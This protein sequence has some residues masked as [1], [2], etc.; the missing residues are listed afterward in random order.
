MCFVCIQ[1]KSQGKAPTCPSQKHVVL[2]A[3]VEARGNGGAAAV[4]RER[5]LLEETPRV[6][7]QH[8]R[9]RGARRRPRL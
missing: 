6:L 5:A 4:A 9:G 2:V 1:Y 3:G 8:E 7:L